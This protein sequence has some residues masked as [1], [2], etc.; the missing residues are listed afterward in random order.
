[1]AEVPDFKELV[2]GLFDKL[3]VDKWCRNAHL[4]SATVFAGGFD[5]ATLSSSV[6]T[7]WGLSQS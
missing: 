5:S 4:D 6:W 1:M 3:V 2:I 7:K